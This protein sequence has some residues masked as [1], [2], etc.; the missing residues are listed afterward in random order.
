[1]PEKVKDEH[2][3]EKTKYMRPELLDLTL[4]RKAEGGGPSVCSNG[5]SAVHDC[6]SGAVHGVD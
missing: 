1:M 2:S 5:S 6:L 4:D 3:K